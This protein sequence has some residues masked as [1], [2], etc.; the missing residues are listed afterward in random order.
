MAE[1][2]EACDVK[3]WH[4]GEDAVGLVRWEGLQL[5]ELEALGDYVVVGEH[6]SFGEA[7]GTA[8]EVEIAAYLLIVFVG[9]D[10]PGCCWDGEGGAM[11]HE[12][13]Y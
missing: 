6:D 10:A 7:G 5:A 11:F 8:G 3:E 2:D 13:L 1:A 12:R 9:W 4:D